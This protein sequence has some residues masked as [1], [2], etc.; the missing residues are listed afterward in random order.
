MSLFLR[1]HEDLTDAL[2]AHESERADII[3][4]LMAQLQ[5]KAIENRAAK[6]DEDLNDDEVLGVLQKEAKKRKE[7]MELYT[8]G[9]R[10]DLAAKEGRE[11]AFITE[12][13]PRELTREEITKVV[14][15]YRDQGIAEF[16]PLIKESM[17]EL[18]GKADG[19]IVSEVVRELLK[20]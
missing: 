3:R 14:Q 5:N 13:L 12:Y 7:A 6:K 17:N 11:L 15:K 1:I 16:A 20:G 18:R 19:K 4:F 9:S 8:Q 10:G 2:K